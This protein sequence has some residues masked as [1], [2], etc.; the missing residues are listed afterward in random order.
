[1]S[2]LM[3][4]AVVSDHGF[5]STSKDVNLL[6]AFS[7][8]GLIQLDGTGQVAS[9]QATI[10]PSGGSGAVMINPDAP[11]DTKQRVADLLSKLLKD[12]ESGLARIVSKDELARLGAWPEAA[13]AVEL[14]PGFT[15]G[16]RTSGPLVTGSSY[17]GMHGYHPD[18]RYSDACF[19]SDREPPVELRTVIDIYDCMHHAAFHTCAAD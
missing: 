8:A 1:M 4:L 10:W 14:K 9:W 16:S 13:F 18:D 7:S 6:S 12:P 5:L 2:V 3:A 15:I 11:A 19:L 17:R